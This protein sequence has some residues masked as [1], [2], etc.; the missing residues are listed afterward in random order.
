M[1]RTLLIAQLN[2]APISPLRKGFVAEGFR[3]DVATSSGDAAAMLAMRRYDAVL[4]AARSPL[5]VGDLAAR[6]AALQPGS[7]PVLGMTRASPE[8]EAALL[9]RGASICLA[10]DITFD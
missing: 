5:L 10:P 3:V 2:D 8:E 1:P 4:A 6:A 7:V 9:E